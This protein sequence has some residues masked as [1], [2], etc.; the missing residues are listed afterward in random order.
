MKNIIRLLTI[1]FCLSWSVTKAQPSIGGTPPSFNRDGGTVQNA[2]AQGSQV[3]QGVSLIA[4]SINAL[5]AEDVERHK[6]SI[7]PPRVAV[8]LPVNYTMENSGQWTT[9]PSGEKIWQLKIKVP[10][11]IALSLL[12][13]N[14]YLPEGSKLFIYSSNK[15]HILGAYTCSNNPKNGPQFATEFVAGDELVLEYVAPPTPILKGQ[16]VDIK[17]HTKEKSKP[18]EEKPAI[19]I[20]GVSYAYNQ[21]FISVREAF[22]KGPSNTPAEEGA[23]GSCMVNIN[24]S[25]G[26]PWQH[27]K[28]GIAATMQKIGAG[29]YIC[30]G[31]LVNNTAE[32]LTPYFLMAQHCSFA[33]T[34]NATDDDYKYWIFYFHWERTGCDNN[35]PLAAYKT[36]TG[37]KKLVSLPI[38]SAS[39]GLL[40]K[41]ENF[42]PA[43]Y[44]VYYNGWD[45]S[46]NPATS[47][48]GIHHPSGDVKKISTVTG[49]ATSNTWNG[50]GFIGAAAAHWL[51]Y[52]AKTENGHGVTEGGSSGSPYFNQNGLV[53]GTLTGGSSQC[54][55]LTGSNFYGK[56]WYHWDQYTNDPTNHMK[57]Y[58]DP[59][60]SGATTIQGRYASEIPVAHFSPSKE[61]IFA[62]E[63]IKM[64]NYSYNATSCEWTFEGGLPAS[65]T[66]ESPIVIW[67]IPGEYTVTLSI[68]GGISTRTTTIEVL[69]KE[70]TGVITI[71]TGTNTDNYPLGIPNDNRYSRSAAIYTAEEMGN[72]AAVIK[73]ISWDCALSKSKFRDI[74]IYLAHSTNPLLSDVSY[75]DLLNAASLV[76]SAS[77]FSTKT[78]WNT[79]S[80]DIPYSYNGTDNLL[81]L[82]QVDGSSDGYGSGPGSMASTFNYSSKPRSNIF[83]IA[84]SDSGQPN[85]I[86]GIINSQRPNIKLDITNTFSTPTAD[87]NGP[88]ASEEIFEEKFDQ[89]TFPPEGWSQKS[90][91]E[92]AKWHTGNNNDVNFNT[93]DPDNNYSAICSWNQ[94][95]HDEWLISPDFEVMERT[96]V[97]FYAG[98]SGKYLTG[99]HLECK[100]SIDGGNSWAQLWTTG[101]TNFEEK[102]KFYHIEKDLSVYAGK[103]AKLAWQYVGADGDLVAL[104]AVKVFE[105]DDAGHYLVY[106]G[107]SLQ[108]TDLSTNTPV[109]WRWSNPGGIPT[110]TITSGEVP[111]VKYL[112]EGLY[113]LGLTV[114]NPAGT[115]TKFTPNRLIVKARNAK[116]GFIVNGGYSTV[117]GGCYMAPGTIANFKNTSKNNPISYAWNFPGGYPSRS[118]EKNP[119]RVIYNHPGRYDV[120]LTA[121]NTK[122]AQTLTLDN[123]INTSYKGDTIANITIDDSFGYYYLSEEGD[124]LLSGSNSKGYSRIAERYEQPEMPGIIKSVTLYVARAVGSTP[125]YRLVI[126]KE[127][128]EDL[129]GLAIYTSP[130]FSAESLGI[131]ESGLVN[132]DITEPVAVDGPFYIAL[133]GF[134]NAMCKSNECLVIYQT[135]NRGE[136]KANSFYTYKSSAWTAVGKNF[137]TEMTAALGLF[138]EFAYT[139]LEPEN[140]TTVVSKTAGTRKLAVTSSTEFIIENTETWFIVEKGTDTDQGKLIINYETNPDALVRSGSFDITGGGVTRTITVKQLAENTL[141]LA[142]SPDTKNIP[143][144]E[145][146]ATVA[147]S[148]TI[149]WAVSTDAPWLT[150]VQ[151]GEGDAPAYEIRYEANPDTAPRTATLTF[152]GSEQSATLIITQ[153][154]ADP[155]LS[156]DR[157]AIAVPR[158]E[159]YQTI[160][161]SSN[162]EWS[163]ESNAGWLTLT[164]NIGNGTENLFANYTLH[165][166]EGARSG[167]ITITAGNLSKQV[168]IT[169][170]GKLTISATAFPVNAGTVTGAGIFTHYEGVTLTA[171]PNEG[172]GFF[173]WRQGETA[174]STLPVYGFNV[175][176][177]ITDLVAHFYSDAINTVENLQ[178]NYNNSTKKTTLTWNA[179]VATTVDRYIIFI[180]GERIATTTTLSYEHNKPQISFTE[181]CVAVETS[182]GNLSD[183]VCTLVANLQEQTITWDQ[184]FGEKD[185]ATEPIF[186]TATASSGLA[187]SY[188]SSN[189][190]VAK[191]RGDKLIM[192]GAGSASITAYQDGGNR[193]QPVASAAKVITINNL[194]LNVTGLTLNNDDAITFERTVELQ[195]TFHG[196]GAPK[197]YQVSENSQLSGAAWHPYLSGALTYSFTHEGNGPKIVYAKLRNEKGETAIFSD[198]IYYKASH[199]KLSLNSYSLNGGAERTCDR[200]VTLTHNVQHGYPT[201]YSVSEN[202]ALIGTVWHPYSEHLTYELTEGNGYKNVF[203]VVANET[204]TSEVESAVIYLDESETLEFHGLTARLYPNPASSYVNIMLEED[205]SSA[206]VTIYSILGE[207]YFSQTFNSSSFSLNIS[208]YPT[209]MLLIKISSGK[210]YVLKRII[211]Q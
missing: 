54:N 72:A 39:D 110:D 46:A 95:S 15:Q 41:L 107:E 102:W 53:V 180:D 174:V 2:N 74:K 127:N 67:N 44:D 147:V 182:T 163:A 40:I 188:S 48:V 130:A 145:G 211:K 101:T 98:Y 135:L 3:L 187:V 85:D 195:F 171:T 122:G 199:A 115:N 21:A 120:S 65:S 56:L 76:Y 93:I 78:G 175:T 92:A 45:R 38:H 81:V 111:K 159:A 205:I 30:S 150:Y 160:K 64:L 8:I 16:P 37:S 25:E 104:D 144:T 169:Q 86:K 14:F 68:N 22:H 153:N 94:D 165:D 5:V 206:H 10:S 151:T 27:Q 189:E 82:V 24:C 196:G 87:F 11:A 133:E 4:P 202:P 33:E 143:N 121:S 134:G 80:L 166:G 106:E 66:E 83:W 32:D 200:T 184:T 108:L 28:K 34:S 71:G 155:Y 173:E 99:A 157:N 103:T 168:V 201:K 109:V 203:F 105:T 112:A 13:D 75:D 6:N 183:K 131:T 191:V 209:G 31:T 194:K 97:S 124:D 23:S 186:L 113:D 181:Y 161:V 19:S 73:S 142:V 62:L 26:L 207:M 49:T 60:N 192:V 137:T 51:V 158:N 129:P 162:L 177:S 91:L 146:S 126:Y 128:S 208:K 88:A 170:A 139:Q 149:A 118:N 70:A 84:D 117:N 57:T 198:D 138:P 18:Y 47:G 42:V 190:N 114:S 116:P 148:S 55:N 77:N 29:Y 140:T 61:E 96:K 176:E 136:G 20:S 132:I 52:F 178:G 123:I 35:S 63:P 125:Q 152:S 197:E 90:T 172:Y 156:V 1:A 164:N 185:Y 154:G 36:M 100:I 50:D 141:N 43:D 58:L 59:V 179:P 204:E 12:Y 9:L 193:Y 79:L 17:G 89:D 167:T 210:D 69:K 7:S 119:V